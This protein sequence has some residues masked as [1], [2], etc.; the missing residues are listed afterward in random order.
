[1]PFTATKAEAYLVI[2]RRKLVQTLLNDVIPVQIFD[3][4]DDMEAKS[5]DDGMN[6]A[7][8]SMISLRRGKGHPVSARGG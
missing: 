2:L 8:V 6:L 7:M 4:H 1:M 5:D 3:E